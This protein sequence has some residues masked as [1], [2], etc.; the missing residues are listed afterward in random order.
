M[1]VQEVLKDYT[2]EI[3]PYEDL[4][5]DPLPKGVDPTKLEVLIFYFFYIFI[6]I[7]ISFR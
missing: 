3:Y 2:R 4:L 7:G 5:S 6:Y 1:P